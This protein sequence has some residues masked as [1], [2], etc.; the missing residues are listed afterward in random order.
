MPRFCWRTITLQLTL[1]Q[2]AGASELLAQDRPLCELLIRSSTEGDGFFVYLLNQE[3]SAFSEV[4]VAPRR[5]PAPTENSALKAA[6]AGTIEICRKGYLGADTALTDSAANELALHFL[7]LPP[8][9]EVLEVMDT[10]PYKEGDGP[11][12]RFLPKLQ[13]DET[14]S[15]VLTRYNGVTAPEWDNLSQ[16]LLRVPENRRSLPVVWVTQGD[17][18]TAQTERKELLSAQRLVAKLAEKGYPN[19]RIADLVTRPPPIPQN[20][21]RKKL[22]PEASTAEDDSPGFLRRVY[23]VIHASRVTLAATTLGLLLG[24]SMALFIFWGLTLSRLLQYARKTSL[25]AAMNEHNPFPD[26]KIR[27]RDDAVDVFKRQREILLKLTKQI[28]D[29]T[30][31]EGLVDR[32]VT[33]FTVAEDQ[34]V[35]TRI[36]ELLQK[37]K[38]LVVNVESQAW[39]EAAK[40]LN[41]LNHDNGLPTPEHPSRTINKTAFQQL[42]Q[43]PFEVVRR[44]K[45]LLD[46]RPDVDSGSLSEGLMALGEKMRNYEQSENDLADLLPN[47]SDA[48]ADGSLPER[49][50][51]YFEDVIRPLQTDC[52]ETKQLLADRLEVE[53]SKLRAASVHQLVDDYLKKQ[54]KP[55]LDEVAVLE[56]LFEKNP[57]VPSGSTLA[58]R[59]EGFVEGPFKDL[60]ASVEI[61]KHYFDVRGNAEASKRAVSRL[62]RFTRTSHLAAIA[63]KTQADLQAFNLAQTE[64]AATCQS[65]HTAGRLLQEY[66]QLNQT[67]RN[68]SLPP[69]SD[70]PKKLAAHLE[71]ELAQL[72]ADAEKHRKSK[73]VHAILRLAMEASIHLNQAISIWRSTGSQSLAVNHLSTGLDQLNLYALALLEKKDLEPRDTAVLLSG[74]PDRQGQLFP[75]LSV[76][77]L[78]Q[79]L[80]TYDGFWLAQRQDVCLGLERADAYLRRLLDKLGIQPHIFELLGSPQALDVETRRDKSMIVEEESVFRAELGT[81]YQ[82][83]RLSTDE[84]VIEVKQL[85]YRVAPRGLAPPDLKTT[86]PTFLCVANRAQIERYARESE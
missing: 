49:Y 48:V 34:D 61:L 74:M 64:N 85:G 42:V 57:G 32:D 37:L 69:D 19:L 71:E 67:D 75:I 17:L 23:A 53:I 83:G 21:Q 2:L 51:S 39:T 9:S 70:R 43:R 5:D 76:L 3:R 44:V 24:L 65:L 13:L 8:R 11:L 31:I 33:Y 30:G 6:L 46:E 10:V 16:R 4:E 72:K 78:I 55:K 73:L 36:N 68:F 45:E 27:N 52:Q 25:I 81:L 7:F 56:E 26:Q 79:T 50:R 62:Q 22:G 86:S 58:Q 20:P 1:L 47:S 40:M 80:R 41:Q 60:E 84:V 12:S 15:E 63:K 59:F 77:A 54:V 29:A 38:N 35:G 82:Q 14:W 28:G 66:H 18:G